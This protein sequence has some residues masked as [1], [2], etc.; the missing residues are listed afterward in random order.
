MIHHGGQLIV[1][2]IVIQRLARL[3]IEQQLLA[4]VETDGHGHTAMPLR[5]CQPGVDPFAAVM[6]VAYSA[7]SPCTWGYPS[8]PAKEAGE[9][10]LFVA[11]AAHSAVRRTE[12]FLL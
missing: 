4:Q 11:S 5:L 7:V 9:E 2:Q 3:F 6:A 8:T 10:A 12:W 1:Q